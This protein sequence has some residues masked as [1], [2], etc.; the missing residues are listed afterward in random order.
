MCLFFKSVGTPRV[1]YNLLD[2]HLYHY[3]HMQVTNEAVSQE[4]LGG[5]GAHCGISGVAHGAWENDVVTL[6]Q[7]RRLMS[8][9]PSRFVEVRSAYQGSGS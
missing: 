5:S 8:F 3:F 2:Y 6:I 4:E 1:R 7:T 9:L